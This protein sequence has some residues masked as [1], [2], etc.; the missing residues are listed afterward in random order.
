[1]TLPPARLHHVDALRGFAMLLGIGLHAALSFAGI[2]WLAVDNSKDDAFRWFFEIVH[3][4]RMQLFFLVSGFFTMML[5]RRRG[6]AAL[7]EQRFQRV[8]VPL[9]LGFVTVVPLLAVAGTW[10][11][12]T[13]P[14]PEVAAGKSPL[15][16]AIRQRNADEVGR[17]VT[18]GGD[19]NAPDPEFGMPPLGWAALYGEVKIART[20]VDNGAD[21]NGKDGSG[22]STLHQ[23]VFMG[24]NEV[25]AL[26][27]ERGADTEARGSGNDTL[28]ESAAADWGTTQFI[29]GL[30]RVPLDAKG[31]VTQGR[32]ECIA[33]IDRH[34]EARGG[35]GRTDDARTRLKE[36]RQKYRDLLTDQRWILRTS[37]QGVHTVLA[38]QFAHLWFLW[39][40]C[41][42]VVLFALIA[43]PMTYLPIPRLPGWLTLSRFR[44]LWLAP[45]TVVPQL[46]MGVFGGGIGPD[47]SGGVIPYPH[48]LAY[49]GV[50][51][52][53]GAIYHD[54]DDREGKLGRWWWLWMGVAAGAFWLAKGNERDPL[55][56]AVP[57]VVFAW[58]MS[59]GLFGLFR[60]LLSREYRVVRYMSDSAYWL[61]L[62]HLP[63]VVWAQAWVREWPYPAWAK[64]AG[65]CVGVTAVLLV[66][67]QLLVRHTY[68][69]T[70]LNG[71][72]AAKAKPPV[73]EVQKRGS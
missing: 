39:F 15:V 61:Y 43:W 54:A 56:S 55:L 10:A 67:Y 69:G 52:F 46:F 19:P 1:M 64:C 32:A 45:L 12:D 7:L 36:A 6:L 9:L 73:V 26:L 71:P 2:P 57:Q 53:A 4:F 11:A 44:L 59:F 33:L 41:W 31:A 63:L 20:L 29:A 58:G 28:Q 62:A 18:A 22:Y 17:L 16:E 65:I 70:I 27:L 37:P 24:R 48:L 13:V 23:A 50:F 25:V 34:R 35:G 30:M 21:V 8:L 3:G 68:L 38:P 40:L 66:A 51:F 72:R 47:T 42:F 60:Q 5:W 14:K 49:Y